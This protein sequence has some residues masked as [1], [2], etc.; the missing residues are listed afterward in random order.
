MRGE[1]V[2]R[3]RRRVCMGLSTATAATGRGEKQTSSWATLNLPCIHD[4]GTCSLNKTNKNNM[5]LT[6]S[7][8]NVPKLAY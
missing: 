1:A 7:P 6:F 4:L 3:A 2:V 5:D 8:Q